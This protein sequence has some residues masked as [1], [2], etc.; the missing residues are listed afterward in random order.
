MR[1]LLFLYLLMQQ[2]F[3]SPLTFE[4]YYLRNILYKAVD[5]ISGNSS[6]GSE[7]S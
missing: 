6:D 7:Q 2:P 5:V 1:L 3:C 4:F